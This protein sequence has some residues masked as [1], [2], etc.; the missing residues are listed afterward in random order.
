[1]AGKFPVGERHLEFVFEI[2]HR[3]QAPDDRRRPGLLRVPDEESLEQVD[4][5]IAMFLHRLP[6]HRRPFRVGKE[7]LFP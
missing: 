7:R 3:P 1:M 4:A 2:R 5:D 6:H